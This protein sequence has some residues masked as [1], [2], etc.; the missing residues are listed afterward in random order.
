M[1]AR[2]RECFLAPGALPRLLS[3]RRCD[4]FVT[5]MLKRHSTTAFANQKY[6]DVRTGEISICMPRKAPLT[7]SG[8]GAPRW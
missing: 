6:F 5:N 2:P 8:L 4:F 1:R 3:K 7:A